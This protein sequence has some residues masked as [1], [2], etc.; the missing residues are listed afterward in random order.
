MA[1]V[2]LFYDKRSTKKEDLH[3]V[4]LTVYH[5][6]DKKRYGLKIDLKESEWAKIWTPKL[7]DEDLKQTKGKLEAYKNKAIEKIKFLGDSFTFDLFELEFFD[8]PSKI[9]KLGLS[10]ETLFNNYIL[11]LKEKGSP[12]TASVYSCALKSL[13]SFDSKLGLNHITS[14]TL[15]DYQ[16]YMVKLGNSFTTVSM[17][18]RSLRKIFNRAIKAGM[19]KP[20]MYPF[21]SNT[22]DKFE[23]P[24]GRKLKKALDSSEIKQIFDYKPE[25]KGEQRGIDFWVFSYLCNG[26]N[27]K[28]ICRLK[29]KDIDG[30]YFTFL[31]AK[32]LKTKRSDLKPIRVYIHPRARVIIERWGNPDKHPDNYVFTILTKGVTPERERQLV[33]QFTRCV[34]KNMYKISGKIGIDKKLSTYSARHSFATV[35]KRKGASTDFI[36]D[37]LGHSDM[38]TTENYL[39]SFLDETIKTNANLL[40]NF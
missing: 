19:I 36:R 37:S 15:E 27:M 10:I 8:N 12:G 30:E 31:R 22:D 13:L 1:T 20:T 23:I 26:L 18:V 9:N 25:F 4:K 16:N 34:N 24:N 7:R 21:G 17:Y 33:Q 29:F 14:K 2:T 32:T 11:E 35:L 40:T 5:E 39:D 6:G 28:D 3:P 38:R